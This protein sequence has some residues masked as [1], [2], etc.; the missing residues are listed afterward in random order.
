MF[1]GISNW[2][3]IPDTMFLTGKEESR[4]TFELCDKAWKQ[5]FELL[6][7]DKQLVGNIG[8]LSR[9]MGVL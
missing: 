7:D 4:E 8:I 5:F 6:F 1:H 3:L 2:F 9:L